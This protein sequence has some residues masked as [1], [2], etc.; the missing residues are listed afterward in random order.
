MLVGTGGDGG[1]PEPG[2]RCASCAG[3]C[4]AGR[5]RAPAAVRLDGHPLGPGLGRPG[6]CLHVGPHRLRL[7]SAARPGRLAYAVTG[8]DGVR[9]LYAP[10]G[11]DLGPPA[12]PVA[13]DPAAGAAFEVVLL[14]PDRDG[15]RSVAHGLAALRARG[16]VTATTDVVV[17]GLS[18]HDPPASELGRLLTAWGARTVPDRTTVQVQA[19]AP[20][21]VPDNVDASE[22]ANTAR[23]GLWGR[24]LVLGGARSGKSAYAEDLLRAE[25]RVTYLATGGARPDDAEWVDRVAVHRRRRPPGWTTVESLDA[26]G[27]L[28]S[29]SNP[30]LVD[31]LGTW[32]TGRMDHYGAWED[33]RARPAVDDEVARLVA[34]WRALRVPVVA[35]SNE[36]GSGVVPATAS[37]RLFRDL[38]GRLNAQIAA[39]SETVLL[40]VAGL[41]VPL[42]EPDSVGSARP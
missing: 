20:G 5:T 33:P 38:L 13:S 7:H 6:D 41:T 22:P 31:C 1:W 37:G 2:C 11:V 35:V 36:V 39:Q 23:P 28:A 3:A 19:S 9:L 24:T 17:V 21:L 32:L 14:G 8:A 4:A 27:V 30:V 42:R 26:A 29:A 40:T 15:L 25:P 34:T 16:A 10:S 12:D 18:H